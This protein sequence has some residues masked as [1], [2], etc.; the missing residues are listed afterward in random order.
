MITESVHCPICGGIE[1]YRHGHRVRKDTSFV[2]LVAQ[3]R[4]LYRIIAIKDT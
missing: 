2:L 4:R 1:I 3:N